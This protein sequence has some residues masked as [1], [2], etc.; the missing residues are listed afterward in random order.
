MSTQRHVRSGLL[1]C[2]SA[3]VLGCPMAMIRNIT[4]AMTANTPMTFQPSAATQPSH[5][6][7]YCDY[8]SFHPISRVRPALLKRKEDGAPLQGAWP[9]R[10]V[11]PSPGA[12]RGCNREHLHATVVEDLHLVGDVG[13]LRTCC[14]AARPIGRILRLK[15][16]EIHHEPVLM[17]PFFR[18]RGG[19]ACNARFDG[20]LRC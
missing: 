18:P 11:T 7:P 19:N 10:S 8:Q 4:H 14:W 5:P 17:L 2:N 16:D 13:G 1:A 3:R 9:L 12:R 20:C 6:C 15:A